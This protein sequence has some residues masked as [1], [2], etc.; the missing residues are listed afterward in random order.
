MLYCGA[1]YHG[2][3]SSSSYPH[4]FGFSAPRV[5]ISVEIQIGQHGWLPSEYTLIRG[6]VI[7]VYEGMSCLDG[8]RQGAV[9]VEKAQI[10][11][12]AGQSSQSTLNLVTSA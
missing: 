3:E 7:Y 10:G 11:G 6:G 1:L 9:C 2:L 5:W 4:S 12:E 8:F